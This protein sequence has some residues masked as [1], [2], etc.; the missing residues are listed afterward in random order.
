LPEADV[1]SLVS[2]TDVMDLDKR[3]EESTAYE[4]VS[5]ASL[6][7]HLR[8]PVIRAKRLSTKFGMSVVFTLRNS[9]FN[10]VQVFLPQLYSDVVTDAD[11]E[12]INS[13]CIDLNLVYKW[14]CE[15]SN[16]YIL[17]VV[18]SP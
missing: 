5:V 3:F 11:I 13:E 12:S 1:I 10:V 8:Y 18:P 15:S 16:A 6:E 17:A 4:T 14:V 7:P 9:D 2:A